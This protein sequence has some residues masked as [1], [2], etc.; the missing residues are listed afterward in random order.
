MNKEVRKKKWKSE[1]RHI[2]ERIKK[3]KKKKEKKKKRNS[4]TQMK[5]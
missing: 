1:G 3:K 4:S 5:E 2:K